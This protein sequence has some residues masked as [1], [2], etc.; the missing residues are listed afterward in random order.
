MDWIY[1]AIVVVAFVLFFYRILSSYLEQS[2]L[3]RPQIEETEIQNATYE[4]Q[5]AEHER[6]A[7]ELQQSL[8]K[9][10]EEITVLEQQR[11]ELRARISQKK[12]GSPR[13]PAARPRPGGR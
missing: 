5:I 4:E 7:E 8:A 2:A 11:T 1:T 12:E 13:K 10:Q 6:V 3:L 9:S